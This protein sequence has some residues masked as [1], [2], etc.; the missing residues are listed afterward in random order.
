MHDIHIDTTQ[1]KFVAGVLPVR[2]KQ[3]ALGIAYDSL[4]VGRQ[5]V[6]VIPVLTG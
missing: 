5:L 6:D 1:R 4:A 2:V 3:C